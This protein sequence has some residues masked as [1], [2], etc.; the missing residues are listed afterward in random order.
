MRNLLSILLFVAISFALISCGDD[1]AASGPIA[2]PEKPDYQ[3]FESVGDLKNTLLELAEEE[4]SERIQKLLDSLESNEQIPFVHMD[5]VLFIYFGSAGTVN[6]AGDF[7]AWNQND[8]N[9]KGEQL[10]GSDIWVLEKTFPLDA[11]LDY[12]IVLD[13]SSWV[14]DPRNPHQQVG[15][16]GP[17]SELRMPDWEYPEETLIYDNIPKGNLSDE[18][19]ISSS[20]LGYDVQYK[21][22]TP[23]GYTGF[24]DLP[25]VYIT[26]GHEYADD[27]MGAA[28]NVMDNLIARGDIKPVIAVFIDPRD[29][30]NPAINR[31][32][33][34]YR[35]NIK[36]ANFV[37]DELVARID[38]DYDT[39][40][41]AM[42]RAIMG[43]SLGGWNSAYF[44]LKR[45]D[46][47]GRL[48]I[49]S[50][51]FD[52]KIISDYQNVAKMPLEIFM[53][54]GV[55]FDTE[56]QARA[57]RDV[58]NSKGYN[59]L[60]IEVNEGHSWGNWRALIDD[61]LIFHFAL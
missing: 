9:F 58:F 40:T 61:P 44:G 26:D 11:R 38:A 18:F 22:Y 8:P 6:W 32:A 48:I 45:N 34:E 29:P 10:S 5:T 7:S 39:D 14:M 49:H 2:V 16:Y 55:I 52:S 33:D 13:G 20:I 53:S 3:D 46:V 21:V 19:L 37:A 24:S 27:D 15:G 51:A 30:A 59:L 36:F 57:M 4:D 35:A 1:D 50:P 60:Y 12:K 42:A 41:S 47:F 23:S 31:R 28:V 56:T 17:N 25:V 54:T 43:T